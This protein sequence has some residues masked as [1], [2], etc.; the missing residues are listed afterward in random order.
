MSQA[1]AE[2]QNFKAEV[3]HKLTRLNSE[4]SPLVAERIRLHL[5]WYEPLK[6]LLRLLLGCP[7]MSPEY[8]TISSA[9]LP[10]KQP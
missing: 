9:Y 8:A 4:Y 7:G 10:L 5:E 6:L 3:L 2:F 1:K